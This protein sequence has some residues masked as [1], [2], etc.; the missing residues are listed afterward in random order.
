MGLFDLFKKKSEC[1]PTNTSGSDIV[2]S[3]QPELIED[4]KQENKYDNRKEYNISVNES[5]DKKRLYELITVLV[6]Y[7]TPKK[8]HAYQYKSGENY[9]YYPKR[10]PEAF[11]EEIRESNKRIHFALD[12]DE[13]HFLIKKERLDKC[14]RIILSLKYSLP[15]ELFEKIEKFIIDEAIM[16]SESDYKDEIKQN[17]KSIYTLENGKET[18]D[19]KGGRIIGFRVEPISSD[20]HSYP[21]YRFISYGYELGAFYRMWYGKGSYEILDRNALRN[22]PC[23]EN[24]V[25]NNDVTRIT[26]YDDIS[27]YDKKDNRDKQM[28]F[29]KELRIDEIAS[30]LKKKEAEERKNNSDPEINIQE[31]NFEHGGVRLIQTYLNDGEIAHRSEADS[32]E[33]R[34]LDENGNELF[35]VIKEL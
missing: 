5:I 8:I 14:I 34:E 10:L 31:G 32:V 17:S 12:G 16:A 11:E 3:P 20:Y 21:G 19:P 13:F 24:I 2:S 23:Y 1:K 15:D 6:E 25:L 33:E 35:S 30:E 9:R 22:F 26:L 29:R 27:N 28:D 18:E 4:N 7:V